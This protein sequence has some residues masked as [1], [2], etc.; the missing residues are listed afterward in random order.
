[1]KALAHWR[2]HVELP[3]LH[4]VPERVRHVVGVEPQNAET[5]EQGA[6]GARHVYRPVNNQQTNNKPVN[7]QQEEQ[8]G[9]DRRIQHTEVRHETLSDR[10]PNP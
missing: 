1:M 8:P 2:H 4:M 6:S 3:V 5:R 7:K 10:K 9:A